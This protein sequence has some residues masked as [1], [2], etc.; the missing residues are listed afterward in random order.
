MSLSRFYRTVW[1]FLNTGL[2][3]IQRLLPVK[4]ALRVVSSLGTLTTALALALDHRRRS[5]LVILGALFLPLLGAYPVWRMRPL[6]HP[7]Y[8]LFLVAPLLI[9]LA[10]A[11]AT[12]LN[13]RR[14]R[15]LGFALV[16][17]VLV[18]DLMGLSHAL[19]D[20]RYARFDARTLSSSIAERANVGEAALTPSND[21]SLWYYDPA[22][23]EPVNLP[24]VMG[25]AGGELSVE[26]LSSELRD[27]P[28]AFLVTYPELR[29]VDPRGQVPFLL[30]S[31]GR[32]ID[33]FVVDR[34]QV[35]H[36]SLGPDWTLPDITRTEAACGPLRL[37][38]VYTEASTTTEGAVT[39]ALRWRLN[40]PVDT[41]LKVAVRLSDGARQIASADVR[42]L[43]EQAR[44]TSLW[45][46]GDEAVNYYVLPLPLGTPPLTHS[47]GVRVYGRENLT[48]QTGETWLPLGSVRLSPASG[49]K[50]DPYGSWRNTEWQSPPQPEV[51]DGLLL[52]G[53]ATRPDELKP[54]DTLYVSLR[55]RALEDGLPDYAPDLT[56]RLGGEIRARDSGTLFERYPTEQ[57]AA[58]ALLI[59]TRE[60]TVPATL[61]ALELALTVEGHV[62]RVGEVSVTREVLRWDVPNEA[63]P[64][65][66]RLA[67]LAE[68]VGYEWTAVST[69]PRLWE[70][71]LYWRAL[72]GAPTELS[73]TVF[74]HV[75]APDGTLLEQHDGA[76]ASNARPTTT[77][78]TG[79]IVADRHR[80]RIVREYSGPATVQVGMYDLTSME[81]VPA[82]DCA[83]RPLPNNSIH[84]TELLI[85]EEE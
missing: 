79:E 9:L 73:Y 84:L 15:V 19:L 8:L 3:G 13:R 16:A 2:V 67:D 58:D 81:R 78:V 6:A 61:E 47:L 77:W 80:L 74:T 55:W 69:E 64:A 20:E 27:R 31:N 44:P 75:L 23:A 51:A 43:N 24:G 56:L 59:E 60:L 29:S 35:D 52:E 53:Y 10:R 28:G 66:A 30:E 76:P 32:L 70:L 33:R 72:D 48:W 17:S 57:W 46:D 22:P 63:K 37:S 62:V 40:D 12:I 39:A 49:Q 11:A 82:R 4:H 50:T 85:G 36:Y 41:D 18:A 21:Y 45:E 71:T 5:Q 38:G 42:L 25:S 68:L 65:C 7:R 14:V 83:D 54:G 34:M 1:V 26:T